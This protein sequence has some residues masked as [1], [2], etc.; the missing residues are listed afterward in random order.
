MPKRKAAKK[1]NTGAK[2]KA[3]GKSTAVSTNVK[4]NIGQAKAGVR[5]RFSRPSYTMPSFGGGGG[6]A[7]VHVSVPH[8]L[9]SF[10]AQAGYS[11]HQLSSNVDNI[12]RALQQQG[13][14]PVPGPS[15]EA[16]AKTAVIGTQTDM[17]PAGAS[18]DLRD[19]DLYANMPAAPVTATTKAEGGTQTDPEQ[20]PKPE[21][22]SRPSVADAGTDP[23]VGSTTST[24][25]D[26]VEFAP[27]GR[28][29]NGGQSNRRTK[30]TQTYL[31]TAEAGTDPIMGP[32][33]T[34]TGSDPIGP[35]VTTTGSDPIGPGTNTFGTQTSGMLGDSVGTQTSMLGH[36]VGTNTDPLHFNNGDRYRHL[37]PRPE[38][39]AVDMS[40]KPA[41]KRK[42]DNDHVGMVGDVG[43]PEF[44]NVPAAAPRGVG[45][46]PHPFEELTGRYPFAYARQYR[47]DAHEAVPM[48]GFNFA[49]NNPGAKRKRDD[50]RSGN[51]APNGAND[52]PQGGVRKMRRV[53][54]RPR[55]NEAQILRDENAMRAARL[56]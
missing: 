56:R 30:R 16:I 25:T 3:K 52:V 22:V 38:R 14:Q 29:T 19:L 24:G 49:D 32:S 6:S 42:S 7:S 46:R 8:P 34:A 18:Q 17:L 9:P 27:P 12:V 4:V 54:R 47:F 48:G 11:I 51:A 40:R 31:R 37:P 1:S 5:N 28:P 13:A 53:G 41:S 55:R 33:T 21:S 39:M 23:I 26:P 36:S 20:G 50:Y 43:R 44:A 35:S 15:A 45:T 10:D 2:A